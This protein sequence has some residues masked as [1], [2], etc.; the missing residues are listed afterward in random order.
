MKE[1]G[2]EV[3]T[4]LGAVVCLSW[5]V[6]AASTPRMQAPRLCYILLHS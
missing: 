5:K 1:E 2:R 6:E 3:W 4:V